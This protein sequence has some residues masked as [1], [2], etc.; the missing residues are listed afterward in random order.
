ML[1][2]ALWGKSSSVIS[3]YLA[4]RA[5]AAAQYSTCRLC[6]ICAERVSITRGAALQGF[7]RKETHAPRAAGAA[8]GD[9]GGEL[10]V[11][12]QVLASL[13]AC[14][15]EPQ[16]LVLVVLRRCESEAALNRK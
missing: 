4:A 10:L 16:Q 12:L 15:N 2:Y 6:A 3:P 13:V 9:G 1:C 8:D 11:R 5:V 14:A 7:R